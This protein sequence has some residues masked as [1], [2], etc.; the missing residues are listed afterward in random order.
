MAKKTTQGF[1]TTLAKKVGPGNATG[2]KFYDKFTQFL[3]RVSSKIVNM[4][5]KDFKRLCYSNK[6]DGQEV[7]DKDLDLSKMNC[8][9]IDIYH[10]QA[11]GRGRVLVAEAQGLK[12]VPV[13]IIATKDVHIDRYL[14]EK[15][16]NKKKQEK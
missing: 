16:L 13:L 14:A 8:P 4:K 9:V 10:K 2:D 6:M 15:G 12:E 7:K 3:P 5:I 11:N 1:S